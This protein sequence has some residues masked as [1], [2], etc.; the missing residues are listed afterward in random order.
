MRQTTLLF[1]TFLTFSA[2]GQAYPFAREFVNGTIVLKDSSKKTGELKWFPNQNEKLK[3]RDTKKGETQKF[4]PEEIIGFSADTLTLI[5]LYNFNAYSDNY[6]LLGKTSTIKHTF[7]QLLDTGKFNIYLVH[8]TGYSAISGTIQAYPN[9]LF[10]NTQGNNSELIA[11]PFA[12]R[13]KDK[14]YE[15]AKENL[16]ILFKDY[17]DIIEK[18]KGYKQQDDFFKIIN[19]VKDVN[20]Q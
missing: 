17:P 2:V 14:R 4:S 16:Y 10:Q 8:I 19:M 15:K 7:G 3:F 18:L 13:M 5:S 1:F 12:I 11:Y 6:A 9:F 20:R